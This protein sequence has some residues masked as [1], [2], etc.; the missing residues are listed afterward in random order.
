MDPLLK[1]TNITDQ[2]NH[3]CAFAQWVRSGAAGKGNRVRAQTVQ[4][5]LCSIGAHFEL[6][7]KANPTYRPNTDR[8]YWKRLERQIEGYKRQDPAPIPKLAVPVS[9]AAHASK[10]AQAATTSK[11]EATADLTNIAFYYLLRV[12]EYTYT[13]QN[14]RKRTQQFR[15]C[16]ITFWN[17]NQPIPIT[18]PLQRLL[19]ADA[20]TMK[21]S[22]Q[23]NGTRGQLIHHECTK[24]AL[25]PV[26]SLARRVAHI[27]RHTTET[28]TPISA[29]YS[30]P[31][32]QQ[33][34][35]AGHINQF[36]KESVKSLGLHHCGY[37]ARAVSSHSLRAGGAMAM[38]LNN[39]NRDTIKKFG[40]WSSDTFLM[41]IHEQIGAFSKG[42]STKMTRTIQF[43][44]IAGPT[45]LEPTASAA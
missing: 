32:K 10:Y 9:I 39:I 20:A 33:H 2:V 4:V 36:V 16:D 38:H 13:S 14:Q 43:Q 28:Q 40:R 41:Y 19:Q 1:D 11:Q 24:T 44:N 37:N 22:N 12:G 29:F 7:N 6:D 8:R 35:G 34:I 18:A 42:V 3:L 5:A 17:N 21:I 27:M 26:K 45:L 15:A 25:S 23:K 31:A 30:T